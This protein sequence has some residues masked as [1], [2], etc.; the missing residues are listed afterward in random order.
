M[1]GSQSNSKGLEVNKTVQRVAEYLRG[2]VYVPVEEVTVDKLVQ[3]SNYSRTYL[4]QEFK[5]A[6]GFSL[7][8]YLRMVKIVEAIDFMCLNG[9]SLQ[10]TAMKVGYLNASTLAK[11]IKDLTGKTA[12]EN[13]E[14]RG[15]EL[16]EMKREIEEANRKIGV[17]E[18]LKGLSDA[19]NTMQYNLTALVMQLISEKLMFRETKLGQE[20]NNF[21]LKYLD[22]TCSNMFFLEKAIEANPQ[23]P[24]ANVFMGLNSYF[25]EEN[26]NASKYL[27]DAISYAKD[28]SR[29]LGQ[30]PFMLIF[31]MFLHCNDELER[32]TEVAAN[33]ITANFQ[34]CLSYFY[35]G[36]FTLYGENNGDYF[37][38]KD[39]RYEDSETFD[40]LM[41]IY[42]FF[43]KSIEC[44][45]SFAPAYHFRSKCSRILN[46]VGHEDEKKAAELN[47]IFSVAID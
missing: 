23:N 44:D 16:S 42:E 21:L 39:V 18:Q 5:K 20:D 9:C 33:S 34:N 28:D 3:V 38:F 45:G 30:E 43:S 26:E 22:S 8:E 10:E 17:S 24:L 6:T 40:E 13:I 35:V 36:L 29:F 4:H 11:G 15:G 31:A 27:E 1:K 47:P 7:M 32:A 2:Q 25:E 41:A 12:R 19:I 37:S 14:T 46:G